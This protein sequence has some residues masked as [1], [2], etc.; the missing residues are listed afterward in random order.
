M[1]QR[2][3]FPTWELSAGTLYFRHSEEKAETTMRSFKT[4]ASSKGLLDAVFIPGRARQPSRLL[5]QQ[6]INVHLVDGGYVDVPVDDRGN[7]KYCAAK[8]T[9]PGSILL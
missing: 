1:S 9:I 3:T 5:L 2:Y 8:K 7:V 6:A 4:S